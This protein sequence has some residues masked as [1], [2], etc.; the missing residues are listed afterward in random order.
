MA[1]NAVQQGASGVDM[2]RNIFQ[3]EAPTAMI[4]AV[5]AV[6]HDNKTPEKAFDL[7]NTLKN[8]G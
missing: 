1:Y 3:S 8:Q 2:G 5:R 4:Q 7:Y 6:V